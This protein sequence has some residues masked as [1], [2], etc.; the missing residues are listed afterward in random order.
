MSRRFMHCPR[1]TRRAQRAICAFV[2][3][4]SFAFS[5]TTAL[6]QSNL[7]P[8][9]QA[10]LLRD[11]IYAEAK[12]NDSDAVIRAIDQYKKLVSDN[13]SSRMVF[14]TPLLWIEAKAAHESGDAPRAL[15]ALGDFLANTD[16]SSDQYKEA[17]ALYSK[18]QADATSAAKQQGDAKRAALVPRIAEL[19]SRVQSD[20]IKIPAGNVT[21]RVGVKRG[22]DQPRQF[23]Y[24]GFSI[25]RGAVTTLLWDVYAADT[26]R[27][28]SDNWN[29]SAT[30]VMNISE[31]KLTVR[32]IRPFV[33]WV[34]SKIPGHWSL[35]SEFEL[36]TAAGE[37]MHR[38]VKLPPP[39]DAYVEYRS[40]NVTNVG[41]DLVADCY[42]SPSLSNAPADG[43]PWTSEC[44]KQYSEIVEYTFW[45]RGDEYPWRVDTWPYTEGHDSCAVEVEVEGEGK[46]FTSEG[47]CIA[48][49]FRLVRH[50]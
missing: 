21:V 12:A 29:G 49:E 3:A 26:G 47:F 40:E 48:T 4:V 6:A 50:N 18:Y 19:L 34:S 35:P 41:G 42:H 11:Q 17:L 38:P 1:N 33:S 10:D 2:L 45:K 46:R 30:T 31:A 7:P 25:M 14:P 9:V 5:G 43:S 8:T 22:P 39:E 13:Q 23:Q 37:F 16:R 27:M 36:R 44:D 24:P 15:K 28:S 20:L 32:D